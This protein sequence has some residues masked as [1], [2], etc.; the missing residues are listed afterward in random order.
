MFVTGSSN[1]RILGFGF[2]IFVSTRII[3]N[4]KS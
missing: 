4:L 1:I 3:K 2:E